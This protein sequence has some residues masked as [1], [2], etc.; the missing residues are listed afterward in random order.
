[1]TTK[2]KEV[3]IGAI[4]LTDGGNK[5]LKVTYEQT[6]IRNNREFFTEF[7]AKK[8]F[9]IHEELNNQ[10]QSLAK[11]LLEICNYTEVDALIGSTEIIGLTYNDS[12]FL[13]SGKLTTISDK[14]F[15]INTPL[16]TFEDGYPDYDKITAILDSIYAETKDT[17]KE[18]R[19]CQTFNMSS[20]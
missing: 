14:V 19:C 11:Y 9:P 7:V 5:G 6:E 10:L 13:I 17:W 20:I 15:A 18:R 4:K 16:I 8:K 2:T 12:G 3:R 1:M